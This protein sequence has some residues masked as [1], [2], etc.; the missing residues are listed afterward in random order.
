MDSFLHRFEEYADSQRWSKGQWSVY[1]SARLKGKALEVHSRLPVKDAQDYEI[2]KEA[3]LKQFNLTEE[4][5]KQK[6]KS[7]RAEDGEAPTQ[8]IARLE[9][10]F[11]RWI[12]SANVEKDFD[13]LMNLIVREQYLEGCPVQLA[14]FLTERK[15]Q[16]LSELA[17]LAEQ[18]LDAHA[19]NKKK[20]PKKPMFKGET[21][22]ERS[23]RSDRIVKSETGRECFNCGK[24]GHLARDCEVEQKSSSS[25]FI[26]LQ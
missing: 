9:N 13:G 10:Y 3:L 2:L 15:A 6:F 7:A 24:T 11:M 22:F 25:S 1:L 17:S 26:L 19:S 8:F 18:Y 5:F 20:W 14:I 16:D 12:D 21:N 4:G 23:G